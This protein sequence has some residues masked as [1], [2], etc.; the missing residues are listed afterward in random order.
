MKL[1]PT[2]PVFDYALYL[3]G[4]I[5][6]NDNL[7]L[8]ALARQGP[9]RTRPA[10]LRATRTSRSAAGR[11]VPAS[12]Y[13]DDAVARMRYI[14]NSPRGLRGARGA[15]I[16]ARLAYIAAANCAQQ[17]IQEFQTSPSTEEAMLLDGPELRPPGPSWNCATTRRACCAVVTWLYLPRRAASTTSVR[18]P[19]RPSRCLRRYC[20]TAVASSIACCWRCSACA[21]CS[22]AAPA[23][24]RG[25]MPLLVVLVGSQYHLASIAVLLASPKNTAPRRQRVGGN[26]AL[27]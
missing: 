3:Q 18:S 11:A 9:L 1:H 26:V 17:A 4:V 23:R 21:G 2:S 15:T 5:N 10:G 22:A 24:Q 12:K 27:A 13:A 14:V 6:F 19:L 20:S 25:A 8:F 16:S 7:G